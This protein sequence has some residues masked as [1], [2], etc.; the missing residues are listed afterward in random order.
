MSSPTPQ[1][2]S[3]DSSVLSVFMF[4]LSHP[5]ITTGKTKAL[6]GW[7]F[8]GKVISLIFNTL[9]MLVIA[10]LPREGLLCVLATSS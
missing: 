4:H 10:F 7:T 8:V 9:S 2:K 6:T 3:I 1:F 5:Y